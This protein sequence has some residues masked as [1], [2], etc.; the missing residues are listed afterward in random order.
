MV[1]TA[2]ENGADRS[3]TAGTDHSTN[4][5]HLRNREERLR[6]IERAKIDYW[7]ESLEEM[8]ERRVQLRRQYASERRRG[9][10]PVLLREIAQRGEKLAA[11]IRNGEKVIAE[12]EAR[13]KAQPPAP[14]SAAEQGG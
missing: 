4:V 13:P 14:E 6:E 2:K 1:T 9:A 12:A 10:D 3:G 11:R 8:R 7:K 5:E